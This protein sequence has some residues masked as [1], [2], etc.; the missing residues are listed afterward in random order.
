MN[1][2][3]ASL[4]I[5]ILSYWHAGSGLGR[6]ADVDALVLKDRD[7]L[8]YLPGRT[9][10]GLLREGVLSCEDAGLV[11]P[12][13]ACS[14]FGKPATAGHPDASTPGMLN[15]SDARLPDKD[16]QW[17]ACQKGTDSR[18]ALYD[19]IA[20]TSLDERGMAD[21][22]TLRTIELCVPLTLV[23]R[24]S[25]PTGDWIGDLQKAC[26][27]VRSLGSHRNRGFGR[28]RIHILE[29]DIHHG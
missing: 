20:S 27:L 2:T 14:L 10:K 9:V 7:D 11:H 1:D 28:C 15:F 25:G 24:V 23:A 6:G 29:G 8:P 22:H 19:S 5:K 12:G 26:C 13:R 16:A 4:E 21:D 3:T 18:T 17:L